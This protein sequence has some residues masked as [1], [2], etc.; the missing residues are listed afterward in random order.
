MGRTNFREDFPKLGDSSDVDTGPRSESAALRGF[1]TSALRTVSPA[2]R[3]A[4]T[5][6]VPMNPEPPVT[7]IRAPA[8][9]PLQKSACAGLIA[10]HGTSPRSCMPP[11]Q[12]VRLQAAA[13]RVAHHRVDAVEPQSAA[14]ERLYDFVGQCLATV[15]LDEGALHVG[16][17]DLRKH[18]LGAVQ[19][20]R[21]RR[22]G[23]PP[24][25]GRGAGCVR[26]PYCPASWPRHR[27]SGLPPCPGTRRRR[28]RGSAA[29]TTS[30]SCARHAAAGSRPWRRRR[31]RRS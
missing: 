24:S 17:V 16:D 28:T 7:K 2:A 9:R 3:Y 26:R 14:Q 25:A 5:R 27:P 18:G 4:P 23:R 1:A 11:E 13:R 22:P 12:Q 29:A 10:R 8:G 19:D 20:L 30:R 6:F 31:R 21:V 15:E